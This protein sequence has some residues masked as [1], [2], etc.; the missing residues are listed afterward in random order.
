M[1]AA[2]A[3][4]ACTILS[5]RIHPQSFRQQ[6][7]TESTAKL[8]SN[9]NYFDLFHLQQPFSMALTRTFPAMRKREFTVYPYPSMDIRK[10]NCHITRKRSSQHVEAKKITEC[11]YAFYRLCLLHTIQQN[12]RRKGI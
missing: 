8:A 4:W 7:L 1:S 12:Q 3:L 2:A 11:F 10:E 5:L 6:N 9:S